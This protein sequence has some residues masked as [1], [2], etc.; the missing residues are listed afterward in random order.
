MKK[1]ILLSLIMVFLCFSVVHAIELSNI[2]KYVLKSAHK[3]GSQIN[4]Q[5]QTYGETLASIAFQES[6]AGAKIYQRNGLIVGDR[7]RSGHFKSLGPMQVQLPAARDVEHWYPAIYQG[8]F[9]VYSPTDEELI[10]ALLT[11]VDFN[12][13]VGAAYF[14]K[15]LQVKKNWSAAILAYNRGAG[16]DGTDPNDYV[17]KVKKWRIKIV[18]PF[19]N[20]S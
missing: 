4:F 20:K 15:M 9:G 13:Q 5:N 11:D 8:Y 17:Y 18:K 19:L 7:T 3:Y 14:K 10:V 1:R 16:N 6:K 12:I 2:Q